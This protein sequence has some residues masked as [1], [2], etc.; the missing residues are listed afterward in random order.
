MTKEILEEGFKNLHRA[1]DESKL[2]EIMK[3]A[4]H[5]FIKLIEKDYENKTT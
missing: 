3:I 4:T 2:G 1:V 5:D